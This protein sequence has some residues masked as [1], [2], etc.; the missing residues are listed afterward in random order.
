[1]IASFVIFFALVGIL[2][3]LSAG[4]FGIG[5]GIIIV[6]ALYWLFTMQDFPPTAIMRL[7]VATS[8]F[9][10][11]FTAMASAWGHWRQHA[12]HRSLARVLLPATLIGGVAGAVLAHILHHQV[13]RNLFAVFELVIALQLFFG[14]Y[15]VQYSSARC[16]RSTLLLGGLG[17]GGFSSV[18]GIGGGTLTVP[19]LLWQRIPLHNAIAVSAVCGIPIAL[20]GAS[21]LIFLGSGVA[22]L[23]PHTIGYL[24]LPAV[25]PIIATSIL[26]AP[27]GAVLAHHLPVVVLRKAFAVL[28]AMVGLRMLY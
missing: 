20:A 21:T 23:P 10:I 28:M 17:I 11:V 12:V 3:G 2:A 1:M 25:I 26:C 24:Y 19:F 15:Q 16:K 18:M 27:L 7:A 4:L 6:P 14:R 9:C 22:E 8:L 13:L 5:G